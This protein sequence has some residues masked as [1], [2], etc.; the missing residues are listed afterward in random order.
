M[1]HAGDTVMVEATLRPWQQP[2]RNVRIPIRLPARL[3]PGNLRLLVSDAGTLDRTLD[4]PQLL[5]A[6]AGP[7]DGAGPGATRCTPPTAFM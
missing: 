6:P 1:V 7:G 5:G 3:E 2:A 4:Q